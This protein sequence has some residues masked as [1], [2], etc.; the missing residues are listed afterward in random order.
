[1]EKNIVDWIKHISE[2]RSE[3]GGFSICPFAKKAFED[4]KIFWSYISGFE[5]VSYIMRYLESMPDY[6]LVAFFNL[7]KNLTN[8]DLLCII[9]SL[10]KEMPDM[11]FLKDHPDAPGYIN[12]VY[13]GNGEYPVIL[14]QPRS[15]LIEAREKLKKTKYY[16]CWSEEYKNEIWN[17]GFE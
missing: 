1:M 11:V 17:Y 9:E 5:D 13:T 8:Q 16:D 6:E 7:G 2:K 14:A 15:K 12:G 4:K 10:N 3:L